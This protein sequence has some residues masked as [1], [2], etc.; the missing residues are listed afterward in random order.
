M[1]SEILPQISLQ[2]GGLIKPLITLERKVHLVEGFKM[3][4]IT[5]VTVANEPEFV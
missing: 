3:L 1:K 2:Q 4:G 5:Q